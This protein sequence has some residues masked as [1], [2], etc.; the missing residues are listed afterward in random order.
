MGSQDF[1]LGFTTAAAFCLKSD[2]EA[3]EARDPLKTMQKPKLSA[4]C[5]MGILLLEN[6]TIIVECFTI[7]W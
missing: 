5:S 4:C 2:E 6:R 3:G 7:M 1:Q